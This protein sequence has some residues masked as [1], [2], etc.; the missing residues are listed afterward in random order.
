MTE[1]IP[2]WL[3]AACILGA[4]ILGA[5]GYKQ[6]ATPQ[7]RVDSVAVHVPGQTVYVDSGKVRLETRI[8]E[9]ARF[10]TDPAALALIDSLRK[11]AQYARDKWWEAEGRLAEYEVNV[12]KVD[13]VLPRTAIVEIDGKELA[14]EWVD[15]LHIER[16][17]YPRDYTVT[18]KPAIIPIR[19][20]TELPPSGASFWESGI[21]AYRSVLASGQ[22]PTLQAGP[23]G[24]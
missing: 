21:M 20:S 17:A 24:Q 1:R 18:T 23:S 19:I 22:C 11:D 2:V 12:E 13:P 7:T 16:T 5:L 8:R 9:V 4:L 14:S 6:C 15:S 10:I 3:A